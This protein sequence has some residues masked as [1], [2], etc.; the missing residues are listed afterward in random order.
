MAA[1]NGLLGR[2]LVP[3][4]A[5]AIVIAL[6]AAV[7]VLLL[8][9]GTRSGTAYFASV[10]NLYAGDTVRILG[11]KVGTIDAVVPEGDKVRVDFS[12]DSEHPVP[13]DAGA[14]IVSPTLVSTRFLQLAPAYSGGPELADGAV[15]PIEKTASPME[16]DDLKSQLSRLSTELGPDGANADGSLSRALDVTAQ[17]AQGQGGRF[18]NLLTQLSGA[19]DTLSQ[20]RGDLFGTV[21][22]LQVFVSAL[23]TSQDQI[24]EFNQRLSSVSEILESNRTQLSR[25]LTEFDTLAGEV[26]TFV[27]ENRGQ[28]GQTVDQAGQVSRALAEQRDEIALAL[29]VAGPAVQNFYNTYAVGG[30]AVTGYLN[31]PNLRNP[32]QF[33][34]SG[35]ASAA[36]SSPE[37]ATNACQTYLGL[38]A[39]MLAVQQ[40]PV[41][42]NPLTRR[43]GGVAPSTVPND[44]T[45]T[46]P[47]SPEQAGT[48]IPGQGGN[49]A[50]PDLGGLL[51]PGGGR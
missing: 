45:G 17:N 37:E 46:P 42:L 30:N 44:T 24:V 13:A 11:V 40:P 43:G 20:G 35:I 16:F 50:V 15:I 2:R 1:T 51:T 25:A 3:V 5:V 34:C 39:Q 4:L 22:N 38:L 21:R 41:G 18:R 32:G 31:V 6:I 12:Y 49:G 36:A 23:S 27:A 33:A 9:G 14:A 7:A 8:S 48:P 29:H 26:Q 19:V 28:I 47:A 10:K